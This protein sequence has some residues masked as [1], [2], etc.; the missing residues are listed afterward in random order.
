MKDKQ[1]SGTSKHTTFGSL[2][3]VGDGGGVQIR[4]SALLFSS[5]LIG[6]QEML[7]ISRLKF[8]L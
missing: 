3:H 1:G 2:H 4:Q 7:W 6:S 8:Y 5:Y